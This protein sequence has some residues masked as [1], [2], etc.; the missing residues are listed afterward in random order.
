MTSPIIVT[1]S[2]RSGTTIASVITASDRNLTFIDEAE[3]VPGNDYNNCVIHLPYALDG[4][5]MLHHIYP[6]AHFIVVTRSKADIIKSMKRIQWC[7]EDVQDWEQFLDDYV[8]NRF[9]LIDQLKSYLPD[10]V[11]LLP[12][13]SLASHRLFV[14]DRSNFTVKQWKPGIPRGPKYWS[15]NLQCI[16]DYY[17]RRTEVPTG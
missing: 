4:Y 8:D 9:Q 11:S 12:Y 6:T 16:T 5:V 15:N 13:E 17:A 14:T 7:R 3:F 1:G 10:Q 2:Q